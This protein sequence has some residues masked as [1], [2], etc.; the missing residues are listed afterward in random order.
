M[1]LTPLDIRRN[2]FNRAWRGYDREEVD[3][4]LA[5]V[6][7]EVEGLIGEHREMA[8]HVQEL[9]HEVEEFRKMERTLSQALVTSQQA[10]DDTR[11]SSQREAEVTKREAQVRSEQMIDSA[12]IEAERMLM[13]ARQKAHVTLEEA[14]ASAHRALTAT[15][16]ETDEMHRVVRAEV[17]AM[18][19]QLQR[20]IERRDSFVAGMRAF[21]RG[22]LDAL[23]SFGGREAP[24]LGPKPGESVPTTTEEEAEALAALDRELAEFAALTAPGKTE[25][26][27]DVAESASAGHET[28]AAKSDEGKPVEAPRDTDD[29]P[30]DSKTN[31]NLSV[32]DA[33]ELATVTPDQG[34]EVSDDDDGTEVL[35]DG[36]SEPT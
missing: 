17:T 5:M 32:P 20:L 36:R 6:S 29:E 3:S 26:E 12:R 16:H 11:E 27:T 34:G 30:A 13:E 2:E 28:N 24:A 33:S 8:R 22:Q 21:L 15:R 18:Q 19:Q 4:F 1:K 7:D 25:A 9:E 35:V 23:E 10:A 14:R 31:Q